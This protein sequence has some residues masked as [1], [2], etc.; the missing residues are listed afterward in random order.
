[1][2]ALVENVFPPLPADTAVALGAFLSGR[3]VLDA[4]TVFGIGW[5]A[6]VGG[7]TAVYWLGR[8]YGREFFKGRV[9][10]KLLPEPVLAHIAAQYHR[11]G[12]YGIFLS[13][14]LPVWR[15]V[16]PPFAGIAGLSP[17]RT[18]IPLAVASALWYAALTFLVATLG[19]NFDDVLHVL[20]RMNQVLMALA[21]ATVVLAA[22][23]IRRLLR[24]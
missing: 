23:A 15:A 24:R 12:T 18:L 22:I 10:K 14:L 20:D 11:H 13:R 9:G 1:M 16:V 4:R 7:A 19:A 3:G 17:A 2:L 6:N 21:V 5:A 8:R